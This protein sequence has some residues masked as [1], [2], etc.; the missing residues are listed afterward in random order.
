M[1]LRV[2]SNRSFSAP[3]WPTAAPNIAGMPAATSACRLPARSHNAIQ[4]L[5]SFP[6][7]SRERT[8]QP[9]TMHTGQTWK[10]VEFAPASAP[11]PKKSSRTRRV[12]RG[13]VHTKL[14]SAL[15][16]STCDWQP[17]ASRSDRV[18]RTLAD[19]SSTLRLARRPPRAPSEGGAPPR[20][21]VAQRHSG[22]LR[23]LLSHAP[24]ACRLEHVARTTGH[25]DRSAIHWMEF[26]HLSPQVG[27]AP[28]L[29][30]GAAQPPWPWFFA[31]P[32]GLPHTD[33][34]KARPHLLACGPDAV[35]A[36][37]VCCGRIWSLPSG[38]SNHPGGR[39]NARSM[40]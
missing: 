33:T 39:S 30:G 21:E 2:P 19:I 15:L 35:A 26:Q 3:T 40:R 24:P 27:R 9:P 25:W 10:C 28:R 5:G 37:S 18:R 17:V 7:T 16:R 22:T 23:C 36:R 29:Q 31:S 11:R 4:R 20:R 8:S 32:V 38:Q 1:P 12:M 34:G 13:Q 14:R 6:A